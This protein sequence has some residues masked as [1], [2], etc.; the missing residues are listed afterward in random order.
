MNNDFQQTVNLRKEKKRPAE[1]DRVYNDESNQEDLKK[2]N[3]PE[4]KQVNQ[5]LIK[6]IILVLVV[7]ITGS[8]IYWSFF[9]NQQAASDKEISW[10]SIKLVDGKIYYGQISDLSADPVE[11]SNVYYD[12]DQI[13]GDETTGSTQ[14]K[15]ETESIR[16]VKRGKETHGPTGTMY[17]VRD[18]IVHFEELGNNSKVLQAILAH[19]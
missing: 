19:E 11:V 6:R 13:K 10:Y 5:G 8:I 14:E 4:V 1:I 9:H 15:S 2:I 18:Q 12:Y 16:L 3:R 17:I 7:I